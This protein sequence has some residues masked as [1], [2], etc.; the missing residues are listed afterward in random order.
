MILNELI[1]FYSSCRFPVNEPCSSA[2]CFLSRL[3]LPVR[4]IPDAWKL[5]L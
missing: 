4:A 1:D 3:T 2:S 5:L